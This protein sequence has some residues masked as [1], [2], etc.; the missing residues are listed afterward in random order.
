MSTM[1]TALGLHTTR[2]QGLPVAKY[3]PYYAIFPCIWA[4]AIVSS[5]ALKIGYG[6]DNNTSPREDV[7]HYGEKAVQDGKIT[8]RELN[9]LKRNEAAHANS[10]ENYPVFLAAV[11]FA[12][13]GGVGNARVN[14]ACAVYTLVRG[15]Y[16]AAYLVTERRRYS[17]VRSLAWWAG[18]FTCFYLFWQS[19]KTLA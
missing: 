2:T 16:V 10:V 15:V 1:A 12:T 11:I 13:V 8:R 17:W 18:N 3:A 9:L 14:R 6:M 4:H 5:R 7:S 19:G